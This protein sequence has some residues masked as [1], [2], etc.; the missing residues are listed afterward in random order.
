[1]SLPRIRLLTAAGAAFALAAS[2][3]VTT[4]AVSSESTEFGNVDDNRTLA[5]SQESLDL[6]DVLD[7]DVSIEEPDNALLTRISIGPGNPVEGARVTLHDADG[8][9][10]ARAQSGA[11]GQAVLFTEEDLP[12]VVEVRVSGGEASILRSKQIKMRAWHNTSRFGIVHVNP[13]STLEAACGL[14][15]SRSRCE[16]AVR[17]YL[18][19]PKGPDYSYEADFSSGG[20]RGFDA[21][22]LAL[23]IRN[24]DT[25]LWNHSRDMAKEVLAGERYEFEREPASRLVD[26]SAT[27]ASDAVIGP[28]AAPLAGILL[29]GF[30]KAVGSGAAQRV[31]GLLADKLLIGMGFM[32]PPGE[33]NSATRE[34]IEQL[35]RDL[36]EIK[37]SLV[38]VESQLSA[39]RDDIA[40]LA[41][42]AKQSDYANQRTAFI[43][44][45]AA[46]ERIAR[47][48]EYMLEFS[49]CAQS[50]PDA[51]RC[52]SRTPPTSPRSGIGLELC[53]RSS[54]ADSRWA[55]GLLAQCAY[56]M[57]SIADY[58]ARYE[59]NSGTNVL[60]GSANVAGLINTS[61][62]AHISFR[63]N[64]LVTSRN[65]QAIKNIGAFWMNLW[66]YDTL[67][68][69]MAG[70]EPR[71][72]PVNVEPFDV[73]D[74]AE[75]TRQRVQAAAT[76][77][78]GEFFGR[79]LPVDCGVNFVVDAATGSPYALAG[80]SNPLGRELAVGNVCD[81]LRNWH[82]VDPT[83]GQALGRVAGYLAS[84]TGVSSAYVGSDRHGAADG[85]CFTIYL[86][87]IQRSEGELAA[88][89]RMSLSVTPAVIDLVCTGVTR[90]G[91]VRGFQPGRW[92]TDRWGMPFQFCSQ[93]F[94]LPQK[95]QGKICVAGDPPFRCSRW[96]D[97]AGAI[98]DIRGNS[99]GAPDNPT[100][101]SALPFDWMNVP[102]LAKGRKLQPPVGNQFLAVRPLQPGEVYL[103]RL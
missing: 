39:V 55:R 97:V 67:I 34:D 63:S 9:V 24:R 13:Y 42:A 57:N 93:P 72:L 12:S 44:Q 6:L 85:R 45:G 76:D 26:A 31:G 71:L 17:R 10:L 18:R 25:T 5:E 83:Q 2:L 87:G 62:W 46:L 77:T 95:F 20:L 84:A 40:R 16:A 23:E 66:S 3:L 94:P 4:P 61:Q 49:E 11:N 22:M 14:E 53:N 78:T 38:R 29:A 90:R 82:G 47:Y 35:R 91:W 30:A 8:T 103:P 102:Q 48:F 21:N 101:L 64:N 43:Q 68:W 27:N 7:E 92:G 81:G 33:D 73:L 80:S 32:S 52:A 70:E 19:L 37:D 60:A 75:A 65:Q 56:V 51:E 96:A 59:L 58:T 28:Q 50:S 41:D 99:Y 1:M 89:L 100:L 74:H 79:D 36:G 69:W 88:C 98:T 15:A 54:E 86:S